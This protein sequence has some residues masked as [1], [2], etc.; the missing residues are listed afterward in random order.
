VNCDLP[1]QLVARLVGDEE[2]PPNSSLGLA[3]TKF[4]VD[5]GNGTLTG[6]WQVVGLTGP[7]TA[8]HI[9]RGAFGV[10]GPIVIPFNIPGNHGDFFTTVN[11]GV[12]PALL[13]ELLTNPNAFYVNIHTDQ[14][15][16]GEIRG[17]LNAGGPFPT[18]TLTA[19]NTPVGPSVTPVP[20]ASA[21]VTPTASNTPTNTSVPTSTNTPTITRTPTTT[22]TPTPGCDTFQGCNGNSPT[23]TNTPT[24]TPTRTPTPSVTPCINS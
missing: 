12:D 8:A 17:Q 5:P 21:T 15:P 6:C 4:F 11:T 10:A 18:V 16:A 14:F 3:M 7:I 22:L 19:T 24:R 20:G 2:T 13:Q 9:H 23:P 1:G